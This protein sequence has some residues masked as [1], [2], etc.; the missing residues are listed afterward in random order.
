MA[1][2]RCPPAAE[3]ERLFLGGLP[4]NEAEALEEHVLECGPCL[5]A[6]KGLLASRETLSAVL[7]DE[8]GGDA[9]DP[10]PVVAE[11]IRNLEALGSAAGASASL[12]AAALELFPTRPLPEQGLSGPPALRAGAKPG[13]DFTEFLEPPLA[14]DELGRLGG[15]RVLEV[16][17]H[18]GMGV[19][20]KAEDVRLRRTVALKAML[21]ALAATARAGQRFLREAQLMATVEHDHVVRIYQAGEDRGVPFLAMELLRG[22]S[23]DRRLKRERSLPVSE[24][25]RI[26]REVAEGLAAAHAAGLIHR[27]VKPANIWLEAPRDRVKILD[28]GLA[29]SASLDAALTHQGAVLGTPAFMAPEQARGEAT[30]ARTDLFSLGIVLYRL[31]SGR[32]PFQGKDALST[33]LEVTTHQPPAPVRLNADLPGDLSDLVLRLLEKD[34]ARRP[35]SAEEVVR[36]IRDLETKLSRTPDSQERTMELPAAAPAPAPSREAARAGRRRLRPLLAAAVA[37]SLLGVLLAAW[38]AG[39]L[40]GPAGGRVPADDGD[41]VIKTDDPDLSFRVSKG[42]V[43]LKDART[44]REYR[45]KVVRHDRGAGEYELE[46]TD[47][48]AD[49]SF[50]TKRFTIKRGETVALSAW[51]ERRKD[52]PAEVEAPWLKEV[53]ALPPGQQ[54]KAVAARLKERNPGFDG[55][56]FCKIEDGVV[57]GLELHGKAVTDLSPL[58]ALPGLRW[59]N[60][61][62]T[63]V[64]DLSPL[65]DTPLTELYC[66]DTR[67]SD[68][69]PLRGM[70]LKH[71]DCGGTAVADLSPLKDTPLTTLF[72][73][74]TQVSDLSPL[75]NLPLTELRCENTRVSD[76]SPLKDLKLTHLACGW[77][78]VSD[79][80]PLR[81]MPLTDLCCDGTAVD[82]LSPLKDMQLTRLLCSGTKVSDLSPL[83]DMPL[84]T[85]RCENARV[86][87]LTPLR[88]MPLK[89]LWC[90]F[91]P[92]RDAALLRSIRTLERINGKPAAEFLEGAK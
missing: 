68:L 3:L 85:L 44:D 78:E 19:V 51:F 45:L 37:L 58:R 81:D 79:L 28:F 30:D 80:S 21:P 4:E 75:K 8:T 89:A 5:D 65:K 47:V 70:R 38:A 56:V 29:R 11:L 27:D 9:E 62:G 59:F 88:G 60:C 87:D 31:C 76:L 72:C 20:Y 32:Q 52:A 71:L 12:G 74:D 91:K 40:H 17:G 14:D 7:R 64:A 46:V 50:R 6:L 55:N 33:L 43:F 36:T 54:A 83:R 16:L 77:T 13:G 84:T 35:A 18:G 39:L 63:R 61:G 82:D 57:T 34:P 41:Y 73:S 53:A 23:L 90:D 67:V 2:S 48:A 24:V 69:S 86:S 42:E 25:L 49:L 66:R 15:Y 10:A 26:G 1:L 92:E 22:E